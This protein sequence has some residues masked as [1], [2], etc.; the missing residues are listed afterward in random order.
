MGAIMAFLALVE[1][2]SKDDPIKTLVLGFLVSYLGIA[3]GVATLV[4]GA[5]ALF[6]DRVKG[7]ENHLVFLLTW[8][9]GALAK[10]LMPSIYGAPD[11]QAW[12]L[13]M[14][15]L[16]FVAIIGMLFH[17]KFIAVVKSLLGKKV[18]SAVGGAG[19]SAGG[20]GGGA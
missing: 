9:F 8:C 19:D 13:H 2:G 3:M 10:W 17:D 7:K 18:S 16:V 20:S 1:D 12:A 6:H 5:K 14:V 11:R 15:I 4:E